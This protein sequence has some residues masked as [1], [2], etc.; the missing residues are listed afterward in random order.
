[1]R[2]MMTGGTGFAGSHTVRRYL[3]AGHSVRL[4]VRDRNKVRRIFDPLGLGIPEQDV[5]VGD[6]TDEESVN[7]AIQGCDAV[8]HGAALVEMK[9]S[10][11]QKVLETNRRGVELVVGGA[12]ARGLPSIVYVSSISIFFTPGC[13]PLHLDMPVAPGTTAYG[14]SKA[15]AEAEVRRMQDE[16]APIRVSYPT[17]IVGPDDPGLSDANHAVYT[18]LKQTG[19]NTSSGFQIVDV[20]DLAEL[21]LRLLELPTGAHRYAAAG[22]MLSWP[23]T[24]RVLDDVTGRWIFRFPIPGPLFRVLGNVGD[25]IKCVYDFSFPL[26]RDA[27]EYATQWP[28]TT[29]E[30]TTHE[31][32]VH[33]RSA[34]ETYADTIRWLYQAGYLKARLVGKLA[35]PLI[36]NRALGDG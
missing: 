20:R 34:H 2:V 23:Q 9:R 17:A 8:Y 5:I 12:V 31:L 10:M 36:E 3:A 30:Q 32:G 35:R 18:F 21:H 1:M 7:R 13:P 14:R 19:V 22:P 27:M 29:A 33:F 26:T 6:I 28:G 4:L 11:A 16:D 25:A 15:E 24:Y